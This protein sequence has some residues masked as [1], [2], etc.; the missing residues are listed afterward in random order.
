[1]VQ[2]ERLGC[3]AFRC[4]EALC[5]GDPARIGLGNSHQ[6]EGAAILAK[7]VGQTPAQI[8]AA[9]RAVYGTEL[10]P[11]LVQP[12]IDL[13]AKYRIIH[14]AFPASEMIAKLT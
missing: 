4:R 13:L 3:G 8:N 12:T 11:S 9:P 5:D 7:Y 14:A 1:M 10:T 2:H 6:A